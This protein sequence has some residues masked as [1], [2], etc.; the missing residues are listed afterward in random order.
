[1]ALHLKVSNS[2]VA[3]TRQ[4]CED[5][6]KQP[7]A[8]FQPNYI[9]TQTAGMNSWLKLQLASDLGIA[10]NFRFLKPNDFIQ[11]VYR[12]LEGEYQ[13]SLSPQNQGW[14]LYS[15]LADE[16]FTMRFKSVAAYY[17]VDAPDKDLKRLA[18]AEKV[19]DLFDQYQMYRPEMIRSWNTG[20]KVGI[21][22]EDWQQY[23]WQEARRRAEGSL[24]DKTRVADYI[25]T[26]L[27]DPRKRARL[28]A[29]M[30][31]IQLLG[32]SV[33][34]AFHLDLFAKIAEHITLRFYMLNPA[35]GVY[36]FDQKAEKQ[37]AI[38]KQKTGF[39]HL[40]QNPGNALLN[41]WGKVIQ[42]TFGLLFEN[43][44]MLNA[45]EPIAS[46]KP[47][48][49]SLLHQIQRDIF[50]N[51]PDT[52]RQ[53][54]SAAD[55]AD[56]SLVIS[57]CFTP[58]REVEALYNYLVHLIDKREE[59]LSARD[60]VV[61]VSDMDTYAPYIKAIFNN[62]P[63]RFPYSLADE[64]YTTGD[65]IA[66]AL[67]AVLSIHEENFKAEQVMQLLDSGYLRQRFGVSNLPLIRNVVTAANFRFG[68]EGTHVDDSIFVSWKYA[69]QRIMYG[70]CMSGSEA[71]FLEQEGIFPLDM[72]EGEDALEIT[73]FCHFMDVLIS[74]IQER[75]QPRPISEWVS[76]L[77]RVLLNLIF[78]ATEV[79]NEDYTILIKQLEQ[80]NLLNTV[81]T[82]PVSYALFNHSIQQSISGLVKSDAFGGHGITF[83]SLIP[84]RSIPFRVVALLGMNFDKFPRK[85]LQLAFNLIDKQ[86]RRGDRNVKENDKHLFLE[87]LLSAGDYLYI[88]YLGQSVKDNTAIPPS[89]L[90]DELI[91]YIQTGMPGIKVAEMLIT[92]HA[93]HGFSRKYQAEDPKLYTYLIES[94]RPLE[95][96]IVRKTDQ[97][98]F[99]EVQLDSLITFLKNP[100]KGYYQKALSIYYNEE[101][102]LLS[103]TELFDLDHLQ[104]WELKNQLLKC[105][106]E[107]I[108]PLR[109]KLVKTGGL[110][111]KNMADVAL[112][113]VN[114]KV[115]PV[116]TCFRALVGAVEER[117]I[118]INLQIAVPIQGELKRE[119][120]NVNLVGTLN[121]VFSEKLVVLS[122]SS[123]ET[124]HLL[125]AYI[126]YLAARAS[127]HDLDLY[128]ISAVKDKLYRAGTIAPSNAKKKLEQLLSLYMAGHRTALPFHTDFKIEPA[129]VETLTFEAFRSKVYDLAEPYNYDCSDWYFL[130]KYNEGH[131][132]L[133]MTVDGYKETA[134]LLL[135]PLQ[136]MFADY[137][138]NPE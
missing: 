6:R 79:E 81:L 132:D 43:D 12:I 90:V 51:L 48:E 70:I 25:S 3:L 120:V 130:N 41:S 35:P 44:R 14:L 91:D 135:L 28:Q 18:L 124:K 32:M 42:N 117:C 107:D 62:A 71:Y 34:T 100:I 46:I 65:S 134:R 36:W 13:Q 53:G 114:E 15:I 29:Q 61:M 126:K 108:H 127:G 103:D 57:S 84:M 78:D 96:T 2:L 11:Q 19:S 138:A 64:N 109:N 59:R 128:F 118:P 133:E 131:F 5:L 55:A 89:A 98:D 67:L 24:P 86:K 121:G 23:L 94:E 76:Y 17:Q 122:W 104:T 113:N 99:S 72:L 102:V 111:L 60:I 80:Y 112:E 136:E 8:V 22:D 40:E 27:A 47:Q 85:D 125:E 129:E 50:H 63:Y 58:V 21:E 119:P 1:M 97:F 69:R 123:R 88:S 95:R 37:I 115:D 116:R 68:I 39:E 137:Y 4:L 92:K 66:S 7:V 38:L 30:P 83:C 74:S 82:E 75:N 20:S 49:D 52:K 54:L 73:R 33:L 45:Y 77:E 9:I 31:F 105:Y 56:G 106:P 101:E 16:A 26:A 87:T 10:A 93:L 110:P